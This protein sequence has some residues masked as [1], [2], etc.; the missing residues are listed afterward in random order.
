[1]KNTYLY[2]LVVLCLIMF[3]CGGEEGSEEVQI[4]EN[5]APTVPNMIFPLENEICTDNNV[6]FQWSASTDAES[7]RIT[8]RIE[9]AENSSFS[10]ILHVQES[11]SE[12]RLISLDRGKAYYWRI[13]AV[14]SRAAASEYSET[15]PFLTEGEGVSN[16]IPFAP[17]LVA[18]AL[19]AEIDATNVILSWTSSDIDS[20]PLTFDVF[21]DTNENPTT[22]V[23]EN[24]TETIYNATNLLPSTKYYFRVVVKDDK[25]G[26]STGQVWSFSTK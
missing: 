2:T 1:M 3:S 14:D 25:G 23:A 13:K 11:F 20:D 15:V 7:N 8:Y 9:V 18:P 10:P 21:L 5:T 17:A 26:I 22:K 4:E 24:Q 12:S 6:V 19:N 16:H